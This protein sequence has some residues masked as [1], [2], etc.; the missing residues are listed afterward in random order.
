MFATTLIG[1][2]P[3]SPR[4]PPDD[5]TPCPNG[6]PDDVGGEGKS[7]GRSRDPGT[8]GTAVAA[9]AGVSGRVQWGALHCLQS[10]IHPRYN[11]P[12]FR[13]PSCIHP[14]IHASTSF[15]AGSPLSSFRIAKTDGW[16]TARR[17][18]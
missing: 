7:R 4:T 2:R 1:R 14:A 6:R 9:E 12:R 17:K 10:N 8:A 11:A 15:L 18:P 13:P 16:R 3:G 5:D